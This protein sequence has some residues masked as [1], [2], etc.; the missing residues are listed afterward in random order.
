[1]GNLPS[2]PGTQAC[3]F[4]NVGID[5]CGPLQTKEK[6]YCNRTQIKAY[7]AVFICLMVKAVHVEVISGMTTEGLVAAL[8]RFVARRGKPNFVYSDNGPNFIGANNEF[9][10]IQDI[11]Q[12]KTYNT[13]QSI[14]PRSRN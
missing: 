13:R 7:V 11:L 8:C 4:C 9:K 6:K 10:E 12:S 3:P 14:A 5:Y 2:I 1:M